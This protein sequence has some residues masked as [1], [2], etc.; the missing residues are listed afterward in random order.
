MNKTPTDELLALLCKALTERYPEDPTTPGVQIAHLPA[1]KDG[2]TEAAWYV[3][4]HRY[5]GSFGTG[6]TVAARQTGDDLDAVL[7]ALAR[8]IAESTPKVTA[9][10]K[11]VRALG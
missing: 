2:R 3:A 4:C 5:T 11:L 7:E 10:R 8:T 1:G 9:Q 6:R